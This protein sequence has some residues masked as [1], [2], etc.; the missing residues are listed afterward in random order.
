MVKALTYALD[1]DI[2]TIIACT[3]VPIILFCH[4]TTVVC[5][6]TSIHADWSLMQMHTHFLCSG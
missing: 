3:Q 6:L 2:I 1:C 5:K 4:Y